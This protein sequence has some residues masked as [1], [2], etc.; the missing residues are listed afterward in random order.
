MTSWTLAALTVAAAAVSLALA[1]PGRSG[2]GGRL[3]HPA[4]WLA[5]VTGLIYLNQV[6][7]TVYVIRVR[8]GDTSFVGRYVPPGWFHLARGSWIGALARHFPFPGVLAPSVLRVQAFFEL[9][10]VVLGYLTV[11]RWFSAAVFR[12]ALRLAWPSAGAY[13]ATFCLIEWSLHN[14]YTVDDVVIRIVSALLVP[15]L[16]VRLS[17]GEERPVRGLPGLLA[18]ALSTLAFGVLVLTVYDTALL[19]DLG[20]AGRWLPVALVAAAV[21]AGTRVAAARTRERRPGPG[22]DSVTRSFGWFLVLFFVPALPV[23]YGLNFGTRYVSAVAGLVIVAAALRYGVRETLAAWPGGL[24]G[25]TTRMAAAVA[26]GLCGAAVTLAAPSGQAE[27]RLLE[28]AGAFFVCAIAGCALADGW[29]G[30]GPTRGKPL[31]RASGDGPD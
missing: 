12:A 15:P 11:C 13:T 5:L 9:P 29:L 17:P 3:G 25:W 20:D 26:A 21:L 19:Y 16:A 22:I 7:F 18:F 2:A 28:G 27:F 24:L 23:R 8:H 4:A 10:F 31:G 1:R 6:L 30:Q 14:P